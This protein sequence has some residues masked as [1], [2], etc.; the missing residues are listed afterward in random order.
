MSSHGWQATITL[1]DLPPSPNRRMSWQARRRVVKP[2]ADSVLLQ[3][4]AIGLRTPLE[5]AHVVATMVH[6]RPPI[7]GYDNAIASLKEVIDAL[8]TGGL[9]VSDA[10]AHL[11]LELVQT[12]G[13][14]RGLLLEVS[15][16]AGHEQ[17]S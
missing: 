6:S 14:Q 3:A 9:V 13:P 1:A 2:L 7:R 12:F 17:A 4:R 8:V 11:R 5:Q 15:P 10:P 16:D